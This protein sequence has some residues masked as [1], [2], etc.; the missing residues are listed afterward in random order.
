MTNLIETRAQESCRNAS[1]F[2]VSELNKFAAGFMLA[3]ISAALPASAYADNAGNAKSAAMG[4]QDG[5]VR[6]ESVYGQKKNT[7][8]RNSGIY[9]PVKNAQEAVA[10]ELMK[11]DWNKIQQTIRPRMLVQLCEEFKRNYPESAYLPQAEVILA[12]AK[13]ALDG[14]TAANL[15]A[16]SVEDPVGNADYHEDL[17]DALQKGDKD[18]AY[19][20][21]IM[22]QNGANGLKRDERRAEHW[23]AFSAELGNGIASWKLSEIYA[24]N[25]QTA[26][27]AKYEKQAVKLGYTAPLRLA[28]RGY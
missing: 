14:Y 16:D 12:G 18:S 23:L 25:G 6:S 13:R 4:R 3:A 7:D 26:D 21:A 28:S 5:M 27:Q 17:V 11:N 9:N 8:E 24:R 20:I 15:S 19:R 2:G 22:Y 10:S 1:M